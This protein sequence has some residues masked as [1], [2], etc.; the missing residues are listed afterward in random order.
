M[1]HF[2]CYIAKKRPCA[3]LSRIT[4]EDQAA[5]RSLCK[6]NHAGQ[7]RRQCVNMRVRV[8]IFVGIDRNVFV[9]VVYACAYLCVCATV[10][11]P[12]VCV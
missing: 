5:K 1:K 10:V 6:G 2:D 12:C 11:S 8:H 7:D 3:Y 4:D 9:R